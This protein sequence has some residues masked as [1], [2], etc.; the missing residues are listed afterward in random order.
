MQW[1]RG[2]FYQ[3]HVRM[4]DPVPCPSP[5]PG[6][7]S[8][9]RAEPGSGMAPGINSCTS[10]ARGS[11]CLHRGSSALQHAPGVLPCCF[12]LPWFTFPNFRVPL[13]SVGKGTEVLDCEAAVAPPLSP[14]RGFMSGRVGFCWVLG[15]FFPRRLERVKKSSLSKAAHRLLMPHKNMT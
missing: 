11:L 7:S 12:Q 1:H 10:S 5:E 6:R 3:A 9:S 13:G 2:G 8:L 15:L 14:S 4:D